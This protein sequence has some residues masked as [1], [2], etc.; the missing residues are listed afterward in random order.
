MTGKVR[1]LLWVTW[2]VIVLLLGACNSKTV[3]VTRLVEKEITSE[4]EVTRLVVRELPVEATRLVEVTPTPTPIPLG[5][6]LVTTMSE[7]VA[8]LNPLLASDDVTDFVVSFIY[9]RMLEPDPFSGE[10]TCHFCEKWTLADR[11]YTFTLRDGLTWSDGDPL[12]ANDFVYTYAA[13]FW[14]AANESLGS[15]HLAAVDGIESVAKLDERTVAVTMKD[16]DC[17][18][19]QDLNLRWLPQH[20]FAPS[21]QYA[22]PVSLQG[23]F[24][25]ADDPHFAGIEGNAMNQA[26]AVASGPFAFDEWLP[27]DHITLVRNSSY[28]NGAPNLDGLIVRLVPEESDQVQL[29]RTGEVDLVENLSPRYLTEIELLGKLNVFKVLSDSYIYLGLQLG[30][31]ASPQPRWLEDENTGQ[32]VFNE[33]HGEHPIL[34]DRLVRQAIA[35]G[36]DRTAIINQIAVGQGV[37]LYSNLL[38]SLSWAFNDGLEPYNYDADRAAALLGEA[39]WLLNVNTG[40]REKD[41]RQ[42]KLTLLTNLSSDT[43]V[44]IGELVQGQLNE[45]GFSIQFEAMEW[46]AFVGLLLGQQFDMVVISWTNLGYN[47]DDSLFFG[48]ENDEPG[49]GFNFVSYYNPALDELWQNAATLPGCNPADRG[50]IYRQIQAALHADLPYNWLYSPLALVG[51]NRRLVGVNPGPWGTWHNVESWYLTSE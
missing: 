4:V 46:G 27:G 21:W 35:Y 16:T 36:V 48:S 39:G 20:L 1:S 22:G 38:P 12:T 25:D 41:G 51:S 31:P 32:K 17:A 9:G 47:P 44:Q 37:P 14:A 34:G 43:R 18:A 8:G 15:P 45:L 19:L 40:I 11:T 3:P 7:E 23:P 10:L 13:L 26:P 28:F 42:L 6:F 5:G 30:D 33:A 50:L 29:L 24:G 49:R 2:V